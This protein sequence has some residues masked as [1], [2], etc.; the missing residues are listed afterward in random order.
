MRTHTRT[1]ARTHTQT[2]THTTWLMHPPPDTLLLSA[3][4]Q[5]ELNSDSVLPVKKCVLCASDSSGCNISQEDISHGNWSYQ[6]HLRNPLMGPTC[7]KKQFWPQ[8]LWGS[9]G[10][11]IQ[12]KGLKFTRGL[13]YPC[14]RFSP[15]NSTHWT[16]CNE[17]KGNNWSNHV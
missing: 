9:R 15:L 14:N 4:F 1:H 7:Y 2:H 5:L 13:D 17:W 12:T 10:L 6:P 11:Q 8:I 16:R 3:H